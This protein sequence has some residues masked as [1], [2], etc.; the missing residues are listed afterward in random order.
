M[1]PGRAEAVE[2]AEDAL[3]PSRAL[4]FAATVVETLVPAARAVGDAADYVRSSA[5][6]VQGSVALAVADC[7][8]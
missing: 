4:P 7:L 2:Q 1:A 3:L 6:S 5:A 8:R